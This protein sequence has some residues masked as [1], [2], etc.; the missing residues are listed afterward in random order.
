M[1]LFQVRS[2][3]AITSITKVSRSQ[4]AVASPLKVGSGSF[5][6]GRPSVWTREIGVQFIQLDQFVTRLHQFCGIR[7]HQELAGVPRGRQFT[8]ARP[9]SKSTAAHGG[10]FRCRPG[11]EGRLFFRRHLWIE[12]ALCRR[13]AR[14]V[15]TGN[16]RKPHSGKIRMAV[17]ST[18]SRSAFR[19]WMQYGLRRTT[20][21]FLFL[22]R[23]SDR[24]ARRRQS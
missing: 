19:Q 14:I 17:G 1:K 12:L 23:S 6:C 7:V 13:I 21:G 18:R 15:A 8:E 24:T 22:L 3:I 20:F 4:W 9:S 5:E 10:D 2:S 11:L 16:T